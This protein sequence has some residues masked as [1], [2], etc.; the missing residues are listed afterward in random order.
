MKR[1]TIILFT[2]IMVFFSNRVEALFNNEIK[3]YYVADK[4]ISGTVT[5]QA[6]GLPLEGATITIKGTNK[7]VISD[8]SGKFTITIPDDKINLF[9]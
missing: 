3:Y 2:A 6:T 5:D 8:K 1:C 7:S 4:V 9:I